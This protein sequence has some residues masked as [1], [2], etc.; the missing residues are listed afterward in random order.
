MIE[1]DINELAEATQKLA[2]VLEE[3]V[4]RNLHVFV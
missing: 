3:V 4:A 2:E 1:H